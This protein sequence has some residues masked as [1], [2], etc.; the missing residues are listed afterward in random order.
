MR[1]HALHLYLEELE[2]VDSTFSGGHLSGVH[3][4]CGSPVR[5]GITETGGKRV[6]HHPPLPFLLPFCPAK[7]A[8]FYPGC[9]RL[10][11]LK[12]MSCNEPVT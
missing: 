3:S 7:V 10:D 5:V 9:S 2:T 1:K 11:I 6:P 12:T 8:C 4:G